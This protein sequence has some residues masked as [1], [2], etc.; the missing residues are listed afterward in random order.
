MLLDKELQLPLL[1]V[2]LSLRFILPIALVLGLLALVVV[3]VVDTL[4][5]R[6]AIRDLNLRSQLV[7]DTLQ[8]PLVDLLERKDRKRLHALF[9]QAVQDERLYALAFCDTNGVLVER[10]LTYPPQLGCSPQLSDK[11][12]STVRSAR[13]NGLLHVTV[14][15]LAVDWREIGSLFM[16]HDMSFI[17]HRVEESRHYV[18]AILL[19]L[20]IMVTTITVL[21]ANLSWRNWMRGVRLMLNV[22]GTDQ[23]ED[24][25]PSPEVLPLLGDVRKLLGDVARKRNIRDHLTMQWKPET[26]RQLLRDQPYGDEIIVVSN[27]EP[28]IHVNGVQGVEVQRPPSGTFPGRT[29]NPSAS[30]P[31]AMKSSKACSA[32]PFSASI[33]H[34]TAR[35]SSRRS[36]ASLKPASSAKHPP[37]PTA[38][39]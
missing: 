14:K 34:I 29:R 25:K 27:R 22:D 7:A 11:G 19:V 31:G 38:A 37:S 3:P 20:G 1:R 5:M 17:Q 35:T 26:L 21:V 6:W 39:S 36:T 18:I 32:A 24:T 33:R 16:A 15:P 4:N 28:Y 30:A 9:D 12:M 8:E 2:R 23:R 10:T 13:T